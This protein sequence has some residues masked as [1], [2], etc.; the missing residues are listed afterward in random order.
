VRINP[1][2]GPREQGVAGRF[3]VDGYPSVFII[4]READIPVKIYPFQR[5]GETFQALSPRDFVAQCQQAG[6]I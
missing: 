2:N 6:G 1:E 3:D 5:A 4:P